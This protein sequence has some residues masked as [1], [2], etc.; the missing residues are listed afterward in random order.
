MNLPISWL[1]EFVNVKAKPHEIAERLTLSGSE[2]EKITDNANGLSKIVVG[3]IKNIKPHPNADKLQIAYVDVGNKSLLEIVCGAPNI[4]VG[5]KVPCVLVGGSVPG[6]KIEARSVRGIK[7]HGMLA[8]PRELG[9]NDDHSGIFILPKD[10]KIGADAVKF[11]GLDEAVLELAI[12][13]NRSDCFSIRGLARE[14]AA[15]YGLKLKPPPRPLLNKGGGIKESGTSASSSLTVKI[16]DKKLCPLYCARVIQGVSV[17]PSPLWLSNRLAQ[18]GI[19]SINNVVDATN[20]VMYELGHPLHA[21]DAN[22]MAGDTI[23]VRRAKRGEKIIA[24]DDATYTLTESMLVVAD[25]KR[26]AAIA[27]VM[28]GKESGINNGTQNIILEAAV[29]NSASVRATSKA[30]GLRSESSSRF[31]KGVDPSIVE[32]AIDRAA[33]SIRDLAGGVVLKGIVSSGSAEVPKRSIKLSVAEAHRL[34]G[35]AVPAS[36][37]KSILQ[38]LG[39][40]VAGTSRP[41]LRPPLGK[42][43]KLEVKIPSWRMHDTREEADLIEEIGRMLDYNKLPK[44]LPMATLASPRVLPLHELRHALRHFLAGLGFTELLT[45]SFYQESAIKL[46]GH[47]KAEHIKLTNPVNDEFPYLRTSLGPWMLEKLSKNSSLLSR[48]AFRLFEI[49]K[50]FR[51]TKGESW[52]AAIGLINTK[53]SDEELFRT[54]VGIIASFTGEQL[55]ME[56]ERGTYRIGVRKRPIGFITIHPRGTVP[57]LRFRSSCAIS[58]LDVEALSGARAKGKAVYAPIPF[59]PVV[60]RDLSLSVPSVVEYRELEATISHFNPLI[61]KVELFDSYHGLETSAS[62]TVRLTCFSTDRTLES[63]EVDVIMEKLRSVLAKKYNVS[64]R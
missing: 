47:A 58:F 42:G 15:L 28:G 45:Y 37:I 11:L 13:P 17:A 6:L 63:K 2:V 64:F 56:K 4:A 9:I 24:L 33:A 23:T 3:Q 61:K 54:L 22:K 49:G 1:K 60:E 48:D 18:A 21:F 14:V 50:V 38:S 51:K 12:T 46:S 32:E 26:A 62:L 59:Y 36:K 16:A 53:Q 34:L 25:E 41:P 39:F 43:G 19:A 40:V 57:G 35:V 52:K 10:A 30:L 7:S 44:T 5:Q 31:E 8:S 27:G 20:Y 29:F 55:T